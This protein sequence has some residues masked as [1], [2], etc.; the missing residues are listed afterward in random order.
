MSDENL[1]MAVGYEIGTKDNRSNKET[2]AT[3][4]DAS[5]FCVFCVFCGYSL[6]GCEWYHFLMYSRQHS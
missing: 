4:L 1:L 3:G 5:Y 2:P 6:Q